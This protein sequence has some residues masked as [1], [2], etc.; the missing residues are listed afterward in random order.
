MPEQPNASSIPTL[1]QLADSALSRPPAQAVPVLQDLAPTTAGHQATALE[2]LLPEPGPDPTLSLDAPIAQHSGVSPPVLTQIVDP[3]PWEETAPAA[4]L[5]ILANTSANPHLKQ[6]DLM[7]STVL[8]A[9]L[10]AE[11]EQ[12]MQNAMETAMAGMRAELDAELPAILER[13]LR[14]VRP[15]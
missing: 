12:V 8:R 5:S 2:A 14:K 11:L 10:Q 13:V 4:P 15:G 6:A 3:P 7:A 1:T 9:A